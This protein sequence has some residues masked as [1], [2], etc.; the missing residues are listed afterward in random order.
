MSIEIK[1]RSY[2]IDG[3]EKFLISGEFHYFRV[4]QKDWKTRLIQLREMGGN[5]IATYVPWMIHEPVEGDI[6]FDRDEH[7][8]NFVAFLELCQELKMNVIAKPGP[9]Q[10]SELVGCGLPGWLFENYPEILAIRSNGQPFGVAPSYM[11]PVFLEKTRKYYKAFAD[12]TRRFMAKNG[13]PISMLQ[14]DNELTG[15]HIWAGSIDYNP[16]TYQFGKEDGY[17]ANFLKKK[18]GTIENVNKAYNK[19]YKCF[20]EILPAVPNHN[21]IYESRSSKDFHDL[22]FEMGGRYLH[23]LE[24]WL[25]EDGINEIMCANAGNPGMNAL[26]DAALDQMDEGF[27]LGSDHYYTLGTNYPQLSPTTMAA[28][29]YL[30]SCEQ[31]KNINMPATAMEMNGGSIYEIPPV[32]PDDI[33]AW[34][35]MNAAFGLK[36]Y[37]YYIYSGGP[38]YNDIGATADVYDYNALVR[39]DGSLNDTYFAIQ[40]LNKLLDENKWLQ[41]TDRETSIN[42]A[43]E[44]ELFRSEFFEY[45]NVPHQQYK[46][47]DFL[48]NGV[49]YTCLCGAYS[50]G[51]K[52]I[53]RE[54]PET[55]K[56]LIV[57]SPTAMS[58]KAQENVVEFIK[59]GGNVFILPTLPTLDENYNEC[60]ILKDFID[61]NEVEGSKGG[62]AI[63]DG[64]NERV[65][66][67]TTKSHIE[68]ENVN[69][70]GKLWDGDQVIFAEKQIGDAKVIF[71]TVTFVTGYKLQVETMEKMI[72]RLGAKPVVKAS[73][74]NLFTSL[75]KGKNGEEGLFIINFWPSRTKTDINIEGKDIGSFDMNGMDVKFIRLK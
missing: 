54:V 72:E 28:L 5:C 55:D 6:R 7:N 2:I 4:P 30:F 36:G 1:G 18:Y 17:Y 22:Y 57:V 64:M 74:I 38:N 48:R 27:L 49:L 58:K 61:I 21:D 32:W 59:R 26:F 20:A 67:Y 37:N 66:G 34:A 16:V 19:N 35:A 14:L 43:Y 31:F 12:A 56:P 39:A 8:S 15:L 9:E 50:P 13:G 70:I 40:R 41:G 75:F 11:H 45:Q 47:L 63:I 44:N 46:T 53:Y 71:G 25:K 73:N 69:P 65:Y 42:I 51:L 52:D 3:E 60:T 33:Y 23:T 68:D 29:K 62:R 24:S 10:Y